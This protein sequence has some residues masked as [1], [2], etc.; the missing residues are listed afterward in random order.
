M[1]LPVQDRGLGRL[2]ATEH[3]KIPLWRRVALKILRVRLD[4]GDV[5]QALVSGETVIV[6]CRHRSLLD[7]VIVALA[8]PVPMVF[9]VTPK[10]SV[11]NRATRIGLRFLERAGL[12]TVVPMDVRSPFGLRSLARMVDDG[13]PAMVFPEGRIQRDGDGFEHLGGVEWL[14]QRTGARIVQIELLGVSRSRF[15]ALEGDQLWPE[16]RLLF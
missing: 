7:G 6:I 14:S 5:A 16:I 15:F 12:G 9:P 3:F 11:R 13:L 1:V 2:M 4:Y 8:S 10:H